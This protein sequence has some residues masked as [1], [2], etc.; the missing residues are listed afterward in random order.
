M[1][2]NFLLFILIIL[3]GCNAQPEVLNFSDKNIRDSFNIDKLDSAYIN[4]LST[5]ENEQH[6]DSLFNL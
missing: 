3:F 1:N 5:V 2:N 6:G 4:L